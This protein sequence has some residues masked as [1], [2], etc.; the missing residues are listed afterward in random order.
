MIKRPSRRLAL[1]IGGMGY[2]RTQ[3]LRAFSHANLGGILAKMG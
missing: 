2:V 1:S 3:T